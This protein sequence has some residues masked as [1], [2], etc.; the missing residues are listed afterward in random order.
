[1]SAHSRLSPSSR[2]RWQKC[3]ASVAACEKYEAAVKSSPS[4]IDGTHSHTLL[5]HCIKHKGG[6]A[7]PKQFIG[8]ILQ[9]HEG[10][11][12]PD[13][14]RCRRVRVATDYIKHRVEELGDGTEVIAEKRVNPKALLGRDDMS[15][16][17]DVQIINGTFIEVIDYKDGMNEVSA[18][19]NA[20]LEQYVFGILSESA[21]S[22]RAFTDIRTTIIQPKVAMKGGTPINSADYTVADFLFQKLPVIIEEAAATD[23]P[24]A[25]FVPGEKQCTYCPHRGNCHAFNSHAMEKAGIKFEDMNFAKDAAGK[26]PEE[27][28]DE[29]LRE[30][31]EAAPLLRKMIESAESEALRRIQSGH[32]MAGLKVVRGPGRRKWALPEEEVAAKLSKM[33]I[34]KQVIWETTLISPAKAEVVKWVKRD[35]SEKQLT[36]RQLEVFNTVL[37]S[38]GD[39]KLT[40][41]P[42]SDKR[43]AVEFA[44]LTKM[45]SAVPEAPAAPEV[46]VEPSLPSWLS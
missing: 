42:E 25:P 39:G 37:V 19:D 1:M 29:Q 14:E 43:G 35:G 9:D 33:G 24:N 4:A 30:M 7:D 32:A 10:V 15:G 18:V 11:F 31:I 21:N 34:P 16:T 40:V 22:K 5:E 44:D 23:D 20:Q 3:P 36:P 41:V 13:E 2:Y 26:Q 46:T 17:V 45:F 12:A 27:L 28:T 38:K 6:I 8:L